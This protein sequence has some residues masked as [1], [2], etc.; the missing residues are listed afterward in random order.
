MKIAIYNCTI[1]A[2]AV[3][4]SCNGYRNDN[5]GDSAIPMI[6]ISLRNQQTAMLSMQLTICIT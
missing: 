6:G 2:S 1:I 5:S 4:I 3:L